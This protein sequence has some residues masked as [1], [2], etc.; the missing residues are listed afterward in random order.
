LQAYRTARSGSEPVSKPVNGKF[1]IGKIAET[2]LMRA[3]EILAAAHLAIDAGQFC[4]RS[5]C[6]DD[7]NRFS[8]AQEIASDRA[9]AAN[10][11][12]DAAA[13]TELHGGHGNHAPAFSQREKNKG[14]HISVSVTGEAEAAIVGM[15]LEQF[16]V[17]AGQPLDDERIGG[18]RFD[19]HAAPAWRQSRHRKMQAAAV[20]PEALRLGDSG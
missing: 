14:K 1:G 5:V 16:K 11:V 4:Y 18:N 3:L 10:V 7:N 6:I 8:A 9:G 2:R 13:I 20:E 17:V 15:T 19:G 12:F